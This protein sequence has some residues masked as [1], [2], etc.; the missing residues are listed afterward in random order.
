[1]KRFIIMTATTIM[2]LTLAACMKQPGGSG[3]NSDNPFFQK[4]TTK[5][6]VPPFD[7]IKVEHFLPAI[8][9]GIKL[10]DQEIDSI[11]NNQ[12]APTF[13]NTI[14]AVDY[15]GQFLSRVAMVF[16]N[17]ASALVTPELEQISDTI[18]TLMSKHNDDMLLNDKLFAR[19]KAV[20]DTKDKAKLNPEQTQLLNKYYKNYT[21][22]GALLNDA[23]KTKLRDLNQ[24]LALLEMKFSNN[25]LTETNAFKLVV[26]KQEDLAGLPA[27][28]IAAAKETAD[29]T[30]NSGKYVFTLKNPSVMPFLQF[31]DN[32][33][34]RKKIWEAYVTRGNHGNKNDN[35]QVIKDIMKYKL[36]K[37]KLLGYANCADYILVNTM[38]KTSAKVFDL[39]NKVWTPA[40]AAAKKDLAAMQKIADAEGKGVKIEPWDW[41]YYE[42]KLRTATLKMEES[43]IKPYFELSKVRDGLFYVIKNLYGVTL[44]KVDG[45]PKFVNDME[46]YEVIGADGKHIGIVSYD[47]FPR[48]SKRGGAWM[49]NYSIQFKQ[50]GKNHT[51]YIPLTL[52]FTKPT[53]DQPAL[54]SIDEVQTL[55]HETGHALH[56]L[57][58]NVTYPSLEGT[59]VYRDFVEMPSQLMEHWATAPEVLKVYAKHYKTG[60]VIPDELIAKI[61]QAGKFGQGFILTELLAAAYLDMQYHVLT[62]VSNLDPQSFETKVLADW[63]LIPEIVSRY[64][65]TYFNHVFGGGYAAGYYSYTWA[66]TLEA[67]VFSIYQEKGIFDQETATAFRNKVLSKGGTAEPEVLYTNFRGFIPGPDALLKNRGL[68]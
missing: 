56:G 9:E 30:N 19:I 55:F 32:R 23:D 12:E 41:R 58:S 59:S 20:Y 61:Q 67:D 7:Q 45:L 8:V 49:S 57:F 29:E 52:N 63:G 11:V 54:L 2:M 53:K 60:E 51:P 37:S 14:A 18:T 40:L 25:M 21:L 36:E 38:A 35:N 68:K 62:D 16:D 3:D 64:K 24:K 31:A 4:W 50:D 33:D 22:N 15:S 26:D 6:E 5:F 42:N 39:L 10:H 66:E 48:Q 43:Q 65:S 27:D 13:D 17:W 1:M 44:K 46:Y 47:F 28:L 34:L